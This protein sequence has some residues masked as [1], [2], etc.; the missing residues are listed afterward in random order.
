M[1]FLGVGGQALKVIKKQQK[2]MKN[3]KK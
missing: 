3:P 1:H 2:I